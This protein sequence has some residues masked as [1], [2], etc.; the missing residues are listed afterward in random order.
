MHGYEKGLV[1]DSRHGEQVQR[2][3]AKV[4]INGR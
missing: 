3:K 2:L 4:E 1:F